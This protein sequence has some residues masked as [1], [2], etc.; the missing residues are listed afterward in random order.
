M[1]KLV[2]VTSALL[3][4]ERSKVR[5]GLSLVMEA[6][7]KGAFWKVCFMEKAP[8]SSKMRIRPSLGILSMGKLM[9]KAVKSGVVVSSTLVISKM[10]RSKDRVL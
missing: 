8:T 1:I 7:M 9:V 6:I 5:E 2:H 4:M 3:S 10:A